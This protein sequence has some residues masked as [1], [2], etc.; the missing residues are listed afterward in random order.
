[1]RDRNLAEC[2]P[3][4]LQKMFDETKN[5]EILKT[6]FPTILISD[7]V[8]SNPISMASYMYVYVRMNVRTR[9]GPQLTH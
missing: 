3:F 6:K 4:L 7:N 5:L 8:C 2:G 1:M 9:A